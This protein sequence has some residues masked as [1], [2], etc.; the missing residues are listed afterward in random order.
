MRRWWH[1]ARYV[2]RIFAAFTRLAMIEDLS[3]PM[4][5]VFQQLALI[6]PVFL[7][8]F[9]ARLFDQGAGHG[10]V[11]DYYS[12]VA[13]GVSVAA[14]LQ[15]ALASFG[16]LLQYAQD[17]GTFETL[18]I[19]PV[20]WVLL[21]IVMTVWHVLLGLFGSALMLLISLALGAHYRL[22][23]LPAFVVLLFLG[24]LATIAIGLIS[25]SLMVLAKRSAP[26]LTLYGLAASIFA[27]TLFP[28]RLIPPWLRWIS[29]L[30]PHTYVIEAARQVLMPVPPE[31]AFSLA[32]AVRG[33]L[34]FNALAFLTGLVLFSRSLQY[35]RKM[36]LLSGY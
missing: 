4:S 26:V 20:P 17:R 28:I 9:V 30:V 32:T 3:Y 23:G 15:A 14:L 11:V 16:N 36:G 8:F 18:L 19:E 25:S 6:I 35:S 7:Y 5:I 33:L 13:I 10:S 31:V 24:V 27:G 12:Y 22:A 34:V 2:G 21:P 29:Y 1:E